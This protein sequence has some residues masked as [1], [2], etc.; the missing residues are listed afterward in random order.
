MIAELLDDSAMS[1]FKVSSDNNLRCV[2]AR[3]LCCYG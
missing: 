2:S 1:S 3:V